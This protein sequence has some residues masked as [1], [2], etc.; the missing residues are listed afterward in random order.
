MNGFI[1]MAGFYGSIAAIYLALEVV[2]AVFTRDLSIAYPIGG[3]LAFIGLTLL[4]FLLRA[5]GVRNVL[6]YVILI[7]L[8]HVII[9]YVVGHFI[10]HFV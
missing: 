10:L 5:N 3:T 6:I 2:I 4:P 9:F 1:V 7:L 8:E